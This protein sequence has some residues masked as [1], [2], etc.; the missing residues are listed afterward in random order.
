MYRGLAGLVIAIVAAG[1]GG[2]KEGGGGAAC[3]PLKVTVDGVDVAGLG[4]GLA[5]TQK[6]GGESSEQVQ[7]FNHAK[8]TCAQVLS[9]SGREV[10]EGE[11]DV[12]ANAGK[13]MMTKGVGIDAHSQMGV[14]VK[15]TSAAPKAVG[16]P[17]TLCVP[18]TTFTPRVGDYKDKKVTVSG[19][20]A[21]TW[22]GV[23]EF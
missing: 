20:F 7:L 9:K 10:P 15:L 14:E 5:I 19:T 4:N 12:R 16:D 2:K 18:E 11:I 6:E 13:S 1:C 23:M 21:G 17:V 3:G 8:A 22:C